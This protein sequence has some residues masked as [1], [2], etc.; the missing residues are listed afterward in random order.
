MAWRYWYLGPPLP[1][2]RARQ[3]SGALIT[4]FSIEF[5]C[6]TDPG[7]RDSGLGP[8]WRLC[9][10]SGHGR[11]RTVR[12]RLR[13]PCRERIVRFRPHS[14]HSKI[15]LGRRASGATCSFRRLDRTARFHRLLAIG[16]RSLLGFDLFHDAIACAAH[17]LL[18]SASAKNK[19][20]TGGAMR[21][22]WIG[23]VKRGRDGRP[24]E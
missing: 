13:Q 1:R 14:R 5:I 17:L 22:V 15:G 3:P 24:C 8:N 16:Q 10:G 21:P 11:L 4:A 12:P 9:A 18:S 2:L 19:G 20:P 7:T 6:V 23:N